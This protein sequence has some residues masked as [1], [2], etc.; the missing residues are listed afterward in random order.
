MQ[1]KVIDMDAMISIGKQHCVRKAWS[2]G[3][4]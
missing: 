1:K 2:G 4:S 3:G